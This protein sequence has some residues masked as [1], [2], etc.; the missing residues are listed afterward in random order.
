MHQRLGG[1]KKLNAQVASRVATTH[2]YMVLPGATSFTTTGRFEI[3]VDSDGIPQG[4]F[5]YCRSYLDNPSAVP[6]DPF[7]LDKLSNTTYRSTMMKG[8]FSSLRDASPKL[9]GRRIIKHTA[10]RVPRDEIDY[11]LQSPDDRV[12]ALGFGRALKPPA[13]KRNFYKHRDLKRL[14]ALA[15]TILVKKALL[16]ESD[17]ERIRNM[18]P[19]RTS[20]GGSRPKAVVEYAKRLWLAKF[21]HSNDNFN[22]ARLEHAMLELARS[23]GIRC[24]RSRV[25]TVQGRDILLAERFDRETT[26]CGYLR[27]RMI[28]GY[29]ALRTDKTPEDRKGWSYA[30]LA[31]ELRSIGAR[32]KEDSKELFRRMVFNALISKTDDDPGNHAIIANHTGWKLSPAF[33]LIPSKKGIGLERDLSSMNCGIHGRAANA[34]N[35]LSECGRF[36]LCEWEAAAIIDAMEERVKNS[37]YGVARREGVTV[38]DCKKVESAIANSGFR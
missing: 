34:Q 25:E 19:F 26:D 10:P 27:Y 16:K 31:E 17:P 1:T 21:N 2:V 29:T 30:L 6:I 28:S 20:M 24:V 11:L 38:A 8:V 36:L 32:P 7:C 33:D 4:R 23:C 37:W 22:C 15:E 14:A 35:M 13:P 12:G 9:W 5:V 3:E 18:I